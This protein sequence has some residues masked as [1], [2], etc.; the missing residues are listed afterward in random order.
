[1]KRKPE[2]R[3]FGT[4]FEVR[5]GEGEGEPTRIE[6]VAAVY[7]QEV[8]IFPGFRE[9]VRPGAFTKTLQEGDARA[10]WQH[11]VAMPLGRESAETLRLTDSPEGL[12]YSID[13]PDTS[14]ARDA[15]EVIGRGDV[16]ESSFGFAV[17]R[18][19][20]HEDESGLAVREILEVELFEVSP[21]TF[22]AYPTTEVQLRAAEAFCDS[23]REH[24][25]TE[26]EERARLAVD[27]LERRKPGAP[28]RVDHPPLVRDLYR[29]RLEDMNPGA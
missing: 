25:L 1:M 12:R 3:A 5:Q 24:G 27:E 19:R 17:V 26:H 6:G 7:D 16:R 9:V 4:A 22:P 20:F 13:P 15:L 29:R 21:V 10:L 11:D 18:D 14:Y 23:L 8:E 28:V 2:K